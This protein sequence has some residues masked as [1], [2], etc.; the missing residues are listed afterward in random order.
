M[1]HQI[2]EHLP[3][4]LLLAG[5]TSITAGAAQV[6]GPAGW[7]IAGLFAFAFGVLLAQRGATRSA[8]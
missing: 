8:G 3:D 7:I 6:Y 1:K 5:A 2:K 4:A